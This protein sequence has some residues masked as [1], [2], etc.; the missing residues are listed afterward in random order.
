MYIQGI[1]VVRDWFLGKKDDL[2][3]FLDQMVV[4]KKNG[5][6]VHVELELRHKYI[7]RME[8]KIIAAKITTQYQYMCEQNIG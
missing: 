8:E 3:K 4:F 7:L 5:A 6:C 1:L 2:C